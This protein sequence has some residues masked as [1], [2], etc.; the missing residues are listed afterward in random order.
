MTSS[1][2]FTKIDQFGREYIAAPSGK[3]LKAYEVDCWGFIQHCLVDEH[4]CVFTRGD[5]KYGGG[6][7]RGSQHSKHYRLVVFPNPVERGNEW[8]K[9]SW[10]WEDWW[11]R[12][13][14]CDSWAWMYMRASG[15]RELETLRSVA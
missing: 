5:P 6:G 7:W 15:I 11:E 14:L 8:N 4:G 3:V 9:S 12:N 1:M 10:R 13:W 2:K